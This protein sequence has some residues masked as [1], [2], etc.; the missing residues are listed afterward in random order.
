M[1]LYRMIKKDAKRLLRSVWGRSLV[2]SLL[3]LALAL[4]ITSAET[5]FL[6]VFSDTEFF[7]PGALEL[8]AVSM[9]SLVITVSA[10]VLSILLVPQGFCGIKKLHLSF[11]NGEE[12]G[13]SP[14]FES[15]SPF[16]R[17]LDTSAFFC[18][19]SARILLGFIVA[20][21]P[22][23][24]LLWF[25]ETYF[26]KTSRTM[27]LLEIGACLL[28]VLLIVF[29][30]VL[31]Q[32]FCQRWFLAPYYFAEGNSAHRS[33]SLSV[34]ATKGQR[35]AIFGFSLSFFGWA[36]LSVLIFPMLWTV[37]YYETA[38]AVYARY[39]ME[40]YERSTAPIQPQE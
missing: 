36:L 20:M 19:Y 26:P 34:K 23:T 22:G 16:W 38:S 5:A 7:D 35:T 8:T 30:L 2:G 21:A 33:F 29:C 31:W 10:A 4:L 24:A 9:E 3:V 14:L 32:I 13:L 25:L 37:P 27:Q 12:K 17:F 11:L 39:L 6:F 1:E 40:R 28:S 18:L 15:F